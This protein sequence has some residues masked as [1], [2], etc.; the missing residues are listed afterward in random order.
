MRWTG[1]VDGAGWPDKPTTA[2]GANELG[3]KTIGQ[4]DT[5]IDRRV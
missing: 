4:A 5:L 1:R 3:H 2:A